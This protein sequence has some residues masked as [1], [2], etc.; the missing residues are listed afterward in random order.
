MDYALIVLVLL[1]LFLMCTV[2]PEG[3]TLFIIIG[4]I[5]GVILSIYLKDRFNKKR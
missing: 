1:F 5:G 2:L 4:S 3:V